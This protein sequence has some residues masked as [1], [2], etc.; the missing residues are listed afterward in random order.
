MTGECSCGKVKY[1][2]N[3][4]IVTMYCCH[5]SKCR[6]SSGSSFS[7][8]AIARLKDFH[9]SDG[10]ACLTSTG[11]DDFRQYYCKHCHA[12][13]YGVSVKSGL[14][15]LLP[16][17]TFSEDPSKKIEF[18]KY[19]ESRASWVDINDELP[20]YAEDHNSPAL[21]QMLAES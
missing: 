8:L 21:L 3:G 2:L 10:E 7:T 16:C 12:W 11:R 1:H 18:H 17:G 19:Y 13:I 4:D 9:L 15:V 14:G 20:K 5:C 6:K